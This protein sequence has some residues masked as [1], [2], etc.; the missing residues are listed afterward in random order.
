M[1]GN[2]PIGCVKESDFIVHNSSLYAVIRQML[3]HS[4]KRRQES[5]DKVIEDLKKIVDKYYC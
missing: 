3:N 2:A 5:I 4:K 1:Q